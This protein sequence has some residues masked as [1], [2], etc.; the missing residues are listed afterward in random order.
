MKNTVKLNEDALKQI[1]AESV[2]ECLNESTYNPWKRVED[3]DGEIS[4]PRYEKDTQPYRERLMKQATHL[5]KQIE[6]FLQTLAHAYP[7]FPDAKTYND[8]HRSAWFSQDSQKVEDAL[9]TA[10]LELR[11]FLDRNN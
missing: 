7:N 6:F 4:H 2:K 3:E 5:Y 10:K 8:F 1:I 9:E 11:S